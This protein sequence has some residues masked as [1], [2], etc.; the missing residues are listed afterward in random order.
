MSVSD[1]STKVAEDDRDEDEEVP[2]TIQPFLL[3]NF[4]SDTDNTL[5]NTISSNWIKKGSVRAP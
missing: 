3:G 1:G 2:S 4:L 5:Y